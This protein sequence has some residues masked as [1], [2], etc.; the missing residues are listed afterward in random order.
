M[1]SALDVFLTGL[2]SAVMLAAPAYLVLQP[3]AALRLTGGWRIAALLPVVIAAPLLLWCA[4]AFV[5]ESNLWPV[6]FLLFAP[7][8]TAYLGIVLLLHR[9]TGKPSIS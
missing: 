9:W 5:D 3:F 8:G 4:Y 6:P 1:S 2:G 7:F